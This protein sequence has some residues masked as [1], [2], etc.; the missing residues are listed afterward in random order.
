MTAA[1]LRVLTVFGTRPEAIKMAPVI[2]A[3]RLRPDIE[4]LVC[5]TGQHRQMLDQVLEIFGV[6]PDF[7]LDIMQ[8]GQTLEDITVRVLS[9][10]GEVIDRVKPDRVLVHGDTTTSFAGALSAFYRKVPVGH[11]EAGLRTG[12]LMSPWPEEM[13][14]RFVDSIADLLWAPT[15]H[16]AAVL[17]REGVRETDIA[18]TGNTVIDALLHTAARIEADPGLVADL[19]YRPLGRRMILVTGHRREN[20]DG[21]LA[22]VCGA[23][24]QL[25]R[26]D[27]VEIVWPVHP[28][29][30]VLATLKQTLPASPNLH[31][32]EPQGY[33]TFVELM[34]RATLIVTDSGGIQEEAPSLGKPVLV[35]RAQTERNEAIAA[36]T[37]RLV[38]TDGAAI[39][40]EANRLLDDPAA[41]RAMAEARNPFGDGG[42]GERIVASIAARHGLAR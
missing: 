37:A 36:G 32:I 38:G 7:D 1:P 20:F 2:A 25:A 33:L 5:V 3:L 41:Y 31:L 28:N 17:R 13:N 21:G 9:S 24:G 16:A 22:E 11:V 14:R 30:T 10:L 12:D 35:T 40:N 8:A 6:R 18:V 27:D 39:L 34:R 4:T 42:A 23:I 29:P 15:E 26:R 19:G